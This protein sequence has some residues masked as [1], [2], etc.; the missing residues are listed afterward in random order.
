MCSSIYGAAVYS[1]HTGTYVRLLLTL[2]LMKLEFVFIAV[3]HLQLTC[4]DRTP[5]GMSAYIQLRSYR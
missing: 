3:E 4:H 5:Y 1:D 2:T